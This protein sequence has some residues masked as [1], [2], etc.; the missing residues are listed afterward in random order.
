MVCISKGDTARSRGGVSLCQWKSLFQ[1]P[2]QSHSQYNYDQY[3]QRRYRMSSSIRYIMMQGDNFTELDSVTFT[4][5][6]CSS[7]GKESK[8]VSA[9]YMTLQQWVKAGTPGGP[10]HAPKLATKGEGAIP[11]VS[12]LE[13]G[14]CEGCNESYHLNCVEAM[15]M[16]GGVMFR[17]PTCN[18]DLAP[19]PLQ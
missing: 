5:A 9:K 1:H 11:P 7:C 17:C 10:R 6:G 19:F 18:R 16:G 12:S 4:P 3:S 8:V 14:F 15:K 13:A 2:S